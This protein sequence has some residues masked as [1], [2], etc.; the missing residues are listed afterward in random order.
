M[1]FPRPT[2]TDLRTQAA[3]DI[4]ASLPGADALLCQRVG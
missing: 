1:P 4:N 3:A 2:L